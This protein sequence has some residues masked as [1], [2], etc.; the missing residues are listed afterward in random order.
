MWVPGCSS[1]EET[2]SLAILLV[3]AAE[4]LDKY[5]DIKIFGTDINTDAIELA[6]SGEFPENIRADISDERLKRFFT[7][8][9]NKY[10]VDSKIRDLMVFAVHDLVRDPPFSN[11]ELISCRNLLIY[12]DT[13]LQKRVLPIF[14]YSLK[15]GGILFL[16]TSET[17]GEA[18]GLFTPID[19]KNKIYRHKDAEI[20]PLGHFRIPPLLHEEEEEPEIPK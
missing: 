5:Y 4:E 19:K 11:M 17:I 10:Q 8:R 12:M 18:S 6:R 14:H 13:D 16:G 1:G 9:G 20:Q 7:K 15:T 2:Y 3:E